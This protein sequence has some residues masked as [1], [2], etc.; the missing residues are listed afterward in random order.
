MFS[1][2][3]V[4]FLLQSLS[5][6]TRCLKGKRL[7]YNPDNSSGHESGE[8]A[9]DDGLG[10]EADYVAASFRCHDAEAADHDAEGA[11][12]GETAHGVGHDDAATF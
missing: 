5:L 3:G 6:F 11:E 2:N 4:L 8:G 9:G 10:T 12:V 1:V 7:Q